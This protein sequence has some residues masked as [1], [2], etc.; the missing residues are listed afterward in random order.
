LELTGKYEVAVDLSAE[1]AMSVARASVGFMP[2]GGGSGG[3]GR[4]A[5]GG[6]SDPSGASI[7]SSIKNLGLKL[8]PRKLRL[9]MLVVDHVEKAPTTN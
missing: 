1:D 9:D 4:N 7:Y 8:A 3:D 6:A 2:S 5:A